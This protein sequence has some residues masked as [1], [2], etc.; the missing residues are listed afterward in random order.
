MRQMRSKRGFTLIE[1]MV[2]VIILASLAAMVLPR[3]ISR[4]DDAKENIARAELAGLT[5][6]LK[7]FRLD[8]HRYPT[9]EE[10]L[11]ALVTRP[12]GVSGWK[13]PYVTREPVDPWGRPIQYRYHGGQGGHSLEEFDVWSLG[14]DDKAEEDNIGNWQ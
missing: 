3:V 12:T 13:R 2:V 9:T 8:C 6:A 11:D 4:E 10:G 5:T 7:N 1:V 14:V